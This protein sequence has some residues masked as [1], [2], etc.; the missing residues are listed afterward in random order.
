MMASE[1]EQ[2]LA[3]VSTKTRWIG[4]SRVGS[5]VPVGEVL[6]VVV[7]NRFGERASPVT[8]LVDGFLLL[9]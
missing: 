9:N 8:G 1:A 2:V 4:R 3:V 6:M 5:G 7:M